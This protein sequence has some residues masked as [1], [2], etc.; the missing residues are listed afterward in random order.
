[1]KRNTLHYSHSA[2]ERKEHFLAICF[3][4]PFAILF[5]VFT[6]LPVLSALYLSLTNYSVVQNPIFVGLKNYRYLLTEDNAFIKAL[7]NTFVF[8]L[9]S[10]AIGYFASFTIAWI[11]DNIKLKMV[12]ALAFYAPSITSGIAMSV[13]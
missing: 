7:S 10:G 13:V 3:F 8:A 1:M 6:M 12:Y 9:F 4:L 2:N 5:V 11:T